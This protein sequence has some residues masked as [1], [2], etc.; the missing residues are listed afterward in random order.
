[1]T[2]VGKLAAGVAHELN[3]PLAYVMANV[4]LLRERV[5]RAGLDEAN[6]RALL[7]AVAAVADGSQRMRDIMDDLR[8]FSRP[9]D[10]RRVVVDLRRIVESS[11]RLVSNEIRHRAELVAELDE[12]VP[13]VLAN[14]SRLG[15]VFINL[16]VNA[17]HAI[18]DSRT[19]RGLIRIRTYRDAQGCAVASVEDNGVG[20]GPVALRRLFEPFFTTKDVG[21]G[22]GLGL[23]V[24]ENI[25]TSLGGSIE[26]ESELGRGSTF[27]VI[28]PAAKTRTPAPQR[29]ASPAST[30]GSI[31]V[32]DDE[33]RLLKSLEML[34]ASHG[35]DVA[36][37]GS[38][39]DGLALALGPRM[40]DV[41]LCDLMMPRVTGMDV[42]E[43]VLRERPEV[44]RRM[45]FLTGG[46]FTPRASAFFDHIANAHIEKPFEMNQ[47]LEAIERV[48][49]TES[50]PATERILP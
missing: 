38:G 34:L 10:Q 1:M 33:P 42:H 22:T 19:E 8:T 5:G 31:L 39:E 15:Q 9:E 47:L 41:I 35:F 26:G 43:E 14:E 23:A 18:P 24:C 28:L 27:R 21:Q 40:F 2:S 46:A 16:L 37:A 3:N 29:A 49:S 6:A 48:R 20:I 11:V 30:G 7:D 17:L 25:V 12:D 13:Q 36:V 44:A 50:A 4:A 45:V 32:I